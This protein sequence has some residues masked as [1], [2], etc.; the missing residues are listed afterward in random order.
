MSS[1]K[2][3]AAFLV[4]KNF[5]IPKDGSDQSARPSGAGGL[6]AITVL[7]VFK[8]FRKRALGPESAFRRDHFSGSSV[9]L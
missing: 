1:L 4:R 3:L 8:H 5:M 2:V 9:K 6:F 7:L